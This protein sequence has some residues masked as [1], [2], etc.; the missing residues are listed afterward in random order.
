MGSGGG[1][2]DIYPSTAAKSG[3]SCT[4]PQI[5]QQKDERSIN[6]NNQSVLEANRPAPLQ[7]H[8]KKLN[9]EQ[10]AKDFPEYYNLQY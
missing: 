9:V 1:P 7:A 2:V 8:G 3:Q 6:A 4:L 10:H 5:P